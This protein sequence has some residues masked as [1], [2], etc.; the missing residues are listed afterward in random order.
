M[1]LD[2]FSDPI[3]PWC[4]IGKRRMESAFKARPDV[5]PNIQ[6]RAFQLNPDMPL[7][8]MD[9]Q[10]YLNTKFG[11]VDRAKQVYGNINVV[12]ASVGLNFKFDDITH[13]PSTMSA[14]RLIRYTQRMM[15]DVADELL[16]V[17][18]TSYFLE[19]KNIGDI[20]IL[21]EIAEHV[22]LAKKT[23]RDFLQSME[24][25]QEVQA[26][27]SQARRLG[28]GGVPYF[29]IDGQYA[30]SGA[31]EPESFYPLFDLSLQSK[32]GESNPA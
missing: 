9:R 17:L 27:D 3:C 30:L 4:F 26:E 23:V 20:D 18:F 1:Q 24:D 6:W 19:G 10:T 28:I 7:Q 2:I 31:Q 15:P 11:G 22:G 25:F 29:I 8:G 12:G 5:K 14:H 13:T 16:E 21:L 32:T